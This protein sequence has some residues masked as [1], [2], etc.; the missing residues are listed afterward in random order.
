ME[1]D[2]S[3]AEGIMDV[4]RIDRVSIDPRQHGVMLAPNPALHIHDTVVP[5]RIL[6]CCSLWHLYTHGDVRLV[7][8]RI[9]SSP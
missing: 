2:I 7:D 9:N 3:I 4:C 5:L 6:F 8:S 1:R